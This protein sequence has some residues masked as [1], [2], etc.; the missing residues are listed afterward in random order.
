MY[1][2]HTTHE[3]YLKDGTGNACA[4]QFRLSSTIADLDNLDPSFSFE[5]LGIDPPIG[6]T[7]KHLN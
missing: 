3:F 5:N 2:P 6:S 1:D 7:N 4:G